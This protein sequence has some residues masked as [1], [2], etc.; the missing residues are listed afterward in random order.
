MWRSRGWGVALRGG[1]LGAGLGVAW[2]GV[3]GLEGCREER[4][5]CDATC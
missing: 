1:W 3:V 4:G 2:C 5:R